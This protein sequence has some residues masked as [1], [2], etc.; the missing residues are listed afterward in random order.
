MFNSELATNR[1]RWRADKPH[2]R[3]IAMP[4]ETK[5]GKDACND[6]DDGPRMSPHDEKDDSGCRNHR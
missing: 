6:L 1:V 2:A 4:Q 5:E 3:L